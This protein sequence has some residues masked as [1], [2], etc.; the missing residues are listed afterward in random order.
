MQFRGML[1]T[2]NYLQLLWVR[3]KRH[4]L[5]T[6]FM[7][8][9]W[10]KKRKE[11]RGRGKKYKQK[12]LV[13]PRFLSQFGPDAGLTNYGSFQLH[14]STTSFEAESVFEKHLYLPFLCA[15]ATVRLAECHAKRAFL[16]RNAKFPHL[17]FGIE[18]PTNVEKCRLIISETPHNATHR[19]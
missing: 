10:K 6:H 15:Q 11:E 17:C 8:D 2:Q 7:G 13:V 14:F 9:P 19:F 5:G 1:L 18:N 16:T 3:M 4:F 12:K